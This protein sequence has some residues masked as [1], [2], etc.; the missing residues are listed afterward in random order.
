[1]KIN[2]RLKA[3]RE[4]IGLKQNFVE[5]K[6]KMSQKRLS[7][8]ENGQVKLSADEFEHICIYGYE[9]NPTIFF[10]DEFLDSKNKTTSPKSQA[11]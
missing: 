3:Y 9:V 11:S 8:I 6:A 5:N 10:N 7:A 1:M 2:E 4:S